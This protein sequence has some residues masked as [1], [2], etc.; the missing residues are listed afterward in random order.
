MTD[1]E[2]FEDRQ[3]STYGR[4]SH[5]EEDAIDV[6]SIASKG[7]AIL[8]LLR[9]GAT[10]REACYELDIDKGRV[11]HWLLTGG[12]GHEYAQ[13]LPSYDYHGAPCRD[14]YLRWREVMRG[15]GRA[16]HPRGAAWKTLAEGFVAMAESLI[17][18][19][20]RVDR[21]D[22]LLRPSR[23]PAK[24]Y[25]DKPEDV[26]FEDEPKSFEDLAATAEQAKADVTRMVAT[27]PNS[28]FASASAESDAPPA[29]EKGV[30]NKHTPGDPQQAAPAP[31]AAKRSL[32]EQAVALL[33]YSHPKPLTL[34][35]VVGALDGE[36]VVPIELKKQ[37]AKHPNV[38]LSK[39]GNTTVCR[40]R[41]A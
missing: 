7:E 3:R 8:A 11:D 25:F 22:P 29:P 6:E 39:V 35:E 41:A 15:P 17:A 19:A 26:T 31:E 32:L 14:F 40:W 23:A 18:L 21:I 38:G 28:P 20:A 24:V 33:E 5:E 12:E 10:L 16:A 1:R 36:R 9:R 37:L 2:S 30:S 13:T 27:W 4:T 34:M